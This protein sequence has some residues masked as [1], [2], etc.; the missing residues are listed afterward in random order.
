MGFKAVSA[1][2]LPRSLLLVREERR[3]VEI[4]SA[5]SLV[6]KYIHQFLKAVH[7]DCTMTPLRGTECLTRVELVFRTMYRL[8]TLLS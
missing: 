6:S 1:M 7:S 4:P 5:W 8:A 2:A 3:D